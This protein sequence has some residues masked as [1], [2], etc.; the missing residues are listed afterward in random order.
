MWS[1]VAECEDPDDHPV[2]WFLSRRSS[3][4]LQDRLTSPDEPVWTSA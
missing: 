2:L 4:E 3:G 1:S